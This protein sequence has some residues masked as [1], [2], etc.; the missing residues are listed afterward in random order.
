MIPTRGTDVNLLISELQHAIEEH[1]TN[2]AVYPW[3]KIDKG[4]LN[5]LN[6]NEPEI[7]TENILSSI[8]PP[9]PIYKIEKLFDSDF[10]VGTFFLVERLAQPAFI[11][12]ADN[13][14]FKDWLNDSLSKEI[15]RLKEA[16]PDIEKVV[17]EH[18]IVKKMSL[19]DYVFLTLFLPT[20]AHKRLL[21]EIPNQ[22]YQDVFTKIIAIFLFNDPNKYPYVEKSYNEKV[23]E[24]SYSILD[25][26][27]HFSTRDLFNCSVA[28]GSL[29]VD[30]KSSASAASPIHK[31]INNIIF[32]N[33]DPNESLLAKKDRM[34]E[35]LLARARNSFAIDSWYDFEYDFL[36]ATSQKTLVWF[37]DDCAE[38]VFDLFFIQ[39]LLSDNDKI[40]VISMPRSGKHGIRFGNDASSLD[41]ERH[42]NN[43]N[44]TELRKFFKK[45]RY[46]YSEEGPCW[47][48]VHG[49][50]LSSD[51][52]DLIL[53][54]SAILVKGSRSYEML[55]GIKT[56][57][58]F[59]SMVCRDFSES[60]FGLDAELGASI[61]IKQEIGLPSFQGFRERHK[62]I[63]VLPNGK[64][65]MLSTM[66]VRDYLQ[67]IR[68]PNY[69]KIL[70]N[71]DNK[72]SANLWI[73]ENAR[74][75]QKTIAEFILNPINLNDI[76]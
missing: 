8:I 19:L 67:A 58:Y 16:F 29:G 61:F 7:V 2:L 70:A 38:T 76:Q 60:V 32:Y 10:E 30:M 24:I 74:K 22:I 72:L 27:Q 13:L 57:A 28:A 41:I 12:S 33:K 25:S 53:D 17:K 69:G 40:K 65:I 14:P 15:V 75:N 20:T 42:L 18:E 9:A 1:K 68:H 31:N 37:H 35:E 46:A 23:E 66:T 26:I 56:E 62:R 44:F 11:S 49:L 51:A 21:E 43:K 50:H 64:K 54:A 52:V 47:G 36:N 4:I 5:M 71:F 55:Q 3:D 39:K 59:A 63:E 73:K 34:R 48:A 6:I 45:G